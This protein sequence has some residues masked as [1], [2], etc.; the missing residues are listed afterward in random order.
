MAED[1]RG[2]VFNV[3]RFCVHDGPGIRTTVFFK[4]CPLNCLWCHNPE[5]KDPA[6]EIAYR[7]A[8]CIGCGACIKACPQGCHTLTESG[9][10]YERTNCTRCGA[11]ARVCPGVLEIV[12]REI[13]ASEVL[14]EVLRDRRFYE[15]SG[16]GLT[17]SGGEPA[18]QLPFALA[19]LERAKENGVCTCVE[20]CGYVPQ[21][22][23]KSLA[24]YTDLF[25]YDCKETD[26]ALHERFT[27][28]APDI[29]LQ[30]LRLLDGLGKRIILRVPI[31]PGFNDRPDHFRR[32]AEMVN[33]LLNVQEIQLMPYHPLGHAKYES[34]GRQYPLSEL[35]FPDKETAAKWLAA[36]KAHTDKPVREG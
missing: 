24:A 7:A 25:L 8:Q 14:A 29:I 13:N 6:P 23:M 1:V 32:V 18:V 9:H 4:G 5:S 12:G 35:S 34:L 28:V 11:C 3:Q 33:G 17:L 26:P 30:N 27:G 22:H 31:I 10:V 21:A 15:N 20:T 36:V 2:C 16:G 19:L